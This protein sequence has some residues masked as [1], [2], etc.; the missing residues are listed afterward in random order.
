ME[1]SKAQ[2]T[3]IENIRTYA[4]TRQKNAIS[5]I[6]HV[7]LMSNISQ[8][9]FDKTISLLKSNARV[10]LHFHPDR[11]DCRMKSVAENFLDDG[12]YKNQFETLISN[13][14][15]A[16]Q[17]G[18][19]RE[20]WEMIIFGDTYH[21]EISDNSQRPK[22]GALDLMQHPDGPA[23]RFGSCY[24]LLKPQISERC[25]FTYMDSHQNPPEKGTIDQF[26]DIIAPLFTEV[27]LRDSAIG[28][29]NLTP[30]KL[31]EIL[32]N[33]LS[34]P[35][36]NP[37]GRNPARNLNHYIEAQIHSDLYLKDDMDI[38]V[39]DPSFKNTEVGIIF[40]KIAEK[41]NIDL[42]WHSG[43]ALALNKIPDDFRGAAMPSLAERITIKDYIDTAMIGQAVC[44]VRNNHSEWS[45]RGSVEDIIQELK[46]LWHVLVKYGKPLKN[47]REI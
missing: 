24:F 9:S 16:P 46:L 7:L 15:V 1:L 47:F 22:Y 33:N 21:Q 23:P 39:A 4:K 30:R 35:F 19:A 37:Y 10:A 41:Y 38:L 17:P 40:E 27:F 20:Q 12:K 32:N 34:G 29:F 14:K 25:T 11:L 3:A 31:I 6:N 44:S 28:E 43:F 18:G 36:K 8:E 13:G 45:D 26:D 42:F 5:S 2:K